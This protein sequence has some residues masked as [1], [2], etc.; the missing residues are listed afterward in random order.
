M[1]QV[2]NHSYALIWGCFFFFFKCCF[3]FLSLHPCSTN[4]LSSNF[5]SFSN[6][7]FLPEPDSHSTH[8]NLYLCVAFLI[9]LKPTPDISHRLPPHTCSRSVQVCPACHI[10]I[11]APVLWFVYSEEVGVG[12]LLGGG[13][14]LLNLSFVLCWTGGSGCTEKAAGGQRRRD[15]EN[16][17]RDMFQGRRLQQPGSNRERWEVRVP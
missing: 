2:Q 6:Y 9:I 3:P 13:N 11:W 16:T 10:S 12:S 14:T 5:H 15:K 4:F 1:H 17:G 7:F 8:W